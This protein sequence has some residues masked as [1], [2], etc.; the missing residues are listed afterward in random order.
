MKKEEKKYWPLCT[1][2]D[3]FKV[4]R[5]KNSQW[6]AL[7]QERLF[8]THMLNIRLY[9]SPFPDVIKVVLTCQYGFVCLKLLASDT[10]GAVGESGA[11]PQI[12]KLLSQPAVRNLYHVHGVL[13]RDVH[14]VLHYTHL[15]THTYTQSIQINRILLSFSYAGD[16]QWE[17]VHTKSYPRVNRS[18]NNLTNSRWGL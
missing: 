10:Q 15:K 13:A 17:L 16:R 6:S 7:H 2:H 11:F 5:S 12:S 1:R 18:V 3:R 4:N 8:N 14:G 9:P